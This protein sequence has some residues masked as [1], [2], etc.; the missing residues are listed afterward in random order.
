V[1]DGVAYRFLP[2]ARSGLSAQLTAPDTLGAGTPGR[3][4][5]PVG[6]AVSR[7]SGPAVEAGAKLALAGP[8]EVIGLDPRQ[9]IRTDPAP[10][11]TD[12]EPNFLAQVEFDQPELPWLFTP[13]VASAQDSLRPW[14]VLVVV[15]RRDNASL[16]TGDAPLPVLTLEPAAE[17][18]RQLPDL[19]DSWAWAHAQVVT[20]AGEQ[21]D[22]VLA[23]RPER[24]A[25]RLI[26]P[27]RLDPDTAYLACVVP[28]FEAGRRAGLGL[29]PDPA[30]EAA[31]RPAWTARTDAAVRL[32][33]YYSW[34]FATGRG[35]D[36]ESLAR[37]LRAR[38]LPAEV[39]EADVFFGAAGP[40]LPRLAPGDAGAT[41]PLRGALRAPE[42]VPSPWPEATREQV[43]QALR[44]ILDLPAT[45]LGGAPAGSGPS[46][47]PPL[48]GR[49][50]ARQETVPADQPRWLRTLNLDARNRAIA[51]LATKI[52]QREQEELMEQAWA[53]VGQLQE[54]NRE[55]RWA[56]LARAVR[57]S[58]LERHVAPLP[59]GRLLELTGAAH[60]RMPVGELTLAATI[61][62]SALPDATVSA[63]F[64]RALRPRGPLA[65]RA[66]APERRTAR[67]F[68]EGLDRGELAAAPPER[69]PD[70]LF[71]FARQAP[72]RPGVDES[73]VRGVAAAAQ[74][75]STQRPRSPSAAAI[76]SVQLSDVVGRAVARGLSRSGAPAD[77]QL[78]A[79][80]RERVRRFRDEA[81]VA[82]ERAEAVTR[83]P[84]DPP[85]AALGVAA[86]RAPVLARL[87]PEITVPRRVRI[88][89]GIP[90]GAR[91]RPERD[92]LEEVI[93][94]PTFPRPAWELVR[95]HFPEHLLP[96]LE[97]VPPDTAT[98]V[99]TNPP[100]T[101][102]LLV[103][104]NH[105]MARELLWREYPTDQRGTPF[106]RFWAPGGRDDVAPVHTWAGAAE[107]G[108]S[109]GG[110]AEGKLV[111]LV[112]G[113]LL[114]RYPSTV[115]YAAPD[116]AGRPRLED[117]AVLLPLF[118]GSLDPDVT[119]VAFD[120]TASQAR[121]GFWFVFEEQPTEPRFGL[122][123]A[124]GF[125]A[126]APSLDQWNDL[127]W[128][129]L[130][131]GPEELEQL[132]HVPLTK[133]EHE[134]PPAGPSWAAS[135]AAMAAILAAQPVRVCLR[136]ADLLPS[137]SPPLEPS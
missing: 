99:E 7:R 136:A 108:G 57:A 114:R 75:A 89:V 18:S 29:P 79:A 65:R 83:D 80:L 56:Q 77:V 90:P 111:L 8:G 5:V 13:A 15:E 104:L 106:R 45:R 135:S 86:M 10:N 72:A 59:P 115:V 82:V 125:G 85:P 91:P 137:G 105:E 112:R 9:V 46:V 121:A 110:G 23:A 87:D 40:P 27:R 54:G 124:A 92:P 67:P 50:L 68:V 41:V 30:D 3:A 133:L 128:G 116:Q 53:Q 73:V 66:Y 42:A 103:G 100:F 123:V 98:L 126:G 43:E 94:A 130:A 16:Q 28:A 76:R 52:V 32:P 132:S 60:R 96:G 17:P 93:A 12:F 88:R 11:V 101:E 48:Y 51:G 64:R 58:L 69:A 25:A 44:G 55:L 129:H 21:V 127:S 6:I 61:G 47:A 74:T 131:A 113:E 71:G 49:W 20:G 33:V 109:V 39:G 95:D 62:A 1:A 84:P 107:L 24:T 134:P 81:T 36:F 63:P 38:P 34:R 122:D 14:L 37:A 118:R 4:R 78:T 120:L 35:G 119:F 22:A 26:C 70:G 117:S 102:A 19:A 31:L 2:W 97:H